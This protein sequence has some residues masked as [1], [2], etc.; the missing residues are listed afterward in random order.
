MTYSLH[1]QGIHEPV[2]STWAHACAGNASPSPLALTGGGGAAGWLR[3]IKR[4]IM[5]LK[6][7]SYLDVGLPR[8]SNTTCVCLPAATRFSLSN[9]SVARL[10]KQGLSTVQKSVPSIEL[11]PSSA[12][13]LESNIRFDLL[14]PLL[15]PPSLP[16]TSLPTSLKDRRL[17]RWWRRGVSLPASDKDDEGN[18]PFV[19]FLR[20][21]CRCRRCCCCCCFLFIC[22]RRW[23]RCCCFCCSV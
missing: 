15:P 4:S 2:L 3:W 8:A 16:P 18:A 10:N 6:M 14:L 5:D 23:R 19:R 20:S 11:V 13:A 21:C 1:S 7:V 22:A 17:R 12:L 9:G